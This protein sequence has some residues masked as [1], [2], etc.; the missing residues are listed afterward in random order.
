MKRLLR[1]SLHPSAWLTVHGRRGFKRRH[2]GVLMSW[3]MRES[4]IDLMA[5][6]AWRLP[7]IVEAAHAIGALGGGAVGHGGLTRGPHRP[8]QRVAQVSRQAWTSNRKSRGFG[9]HACKSARQCLGTALSSV[10]SVVPQCCSGVFPVA[11][12]LSV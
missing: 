6:L 12:R 8:A 9:T 5:V 4:S 2:L 11:S 3:P 10:A 1:L 7:R